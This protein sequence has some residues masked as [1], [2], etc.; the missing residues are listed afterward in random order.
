MALAG[1]RAQ[2]LDETLGAAGKARRNGLAVACD[3]TRCRLGQPHCSTAR[4]PGF[5][6]LDVLFNNAGT[7]APAVRS[8]TSATRNGARR[9]RPTSPARSSAP[10]S[11]FRM[12]K[13]QDPRGGRIINNGS[14]SA[15]APRPLGALHR[16]QARDDRADQVDLAGRPR[17]RHRLRADRHRQRARPS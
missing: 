14:I 4:V 12:M 1:R 8:R 6:P 9:R 13:A 7:G 17:L 11:A 15:H 5:G 3:V 16:D 10:R 2:P